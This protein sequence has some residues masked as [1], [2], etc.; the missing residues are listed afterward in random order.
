MPRSKETAIAAGVAIN[1]TQ[2]SMKRRT[3]WHDYRQ[4]GTY[5]LTLIVEGRKP[6]LGR[7]V[8]EPCGKAQGTV[9]GTGASVPAASPAGFASVPAASPAGKITARV[10][11]SA[12]G[13][14]IR[15]EEIRKIAKFYPMVEVWKLCIMPDHIHMIVR[16]KADL[17]EG[18]HLGQV[19]RGFKTGCSRAWWRLVPCGKA[20]GTVAGNAQGTVVGN[21]QRTVAGPGAASVPAASPQ[22]IAS[23]PAV[24]PAGKLRPVLFERGYCDKLLMHEGQPET[25]KR[26]LDDN[27]R[28]LA[29]KRLRPDYFTVINNAQVVGHS[30]QLVG[31]RF[32]LDIPQKMAVI[33]HRRYTDTEYAEY[34]RQWLACGEAGGVLVSAAIATREKAVMRE[35]MD[36][37]YHV[38]LLR[39]N[40]F[41]PLYKPA[42]EAFEACTEGRLLQISPWE[43]H[44]ELKT[45]TRQQCLQLNKMAEDIVAG[46]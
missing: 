37:G 16:V 27:P 22:G 23:A 4:R 20:Q 34:R 24:F 9:A 15:D 3:P 5:M 17:P 45:I 32:L 26:Y 19:V 30:C 13:R 35:A 12:L 28:R 25:W 8:V 38:I 36:R 18:K 31:N 11:L 44:M 2:H 7:L 1:E 6:L 21:A 33:V 40:G 39:E 42:G 46:E 10:E 14:A 29:I 43:Y 41:P